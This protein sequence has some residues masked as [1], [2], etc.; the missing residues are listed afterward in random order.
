MLLRHQPTN[1]SSVLIFIKSSLVFNSHFVIVFVLVTCST[2]F[3]GQPP[4]F[5]FCII[6]SNFLEFQTIVLG[7]IPQLS[8]SDIAQS[9]LCLIPSQIYKQRL[10]SCTP[11]LLIKHAP[12]IYPKCI[13][14]FLQ[15]TV[16]HEKSLG[17]FTKPN[18]HTV[19]IGLDVPP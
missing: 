4:V 19:S 11:H 13:Q 8:Q 1:K 18:M 3:L 5:V 15:G 12:Y 7:S 2:T 10:I 17:I 9:N 16:M 14:Q 6:G